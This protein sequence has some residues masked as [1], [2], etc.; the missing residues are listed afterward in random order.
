[1]YLFVCSQSFLRS[2]TAE[3]LCLLGGVEARCCGIDSSAL[4][5]VNNE[6][7]R[8]ADQVFCMEKRHR[9]GIKTY[10]GFDAAR[11]AVLNIPDDFE[12]FDPELVRLLVQK[13]GGL[14]EEVAEA[15]AHGYTMWH[16]GARRAKSYDPKMTVE[17]RIGLAR[18]LLKD[19]DPD[20]FSRDELDLVGAI[21]TG[22]HIVV[23]PPSLYLAREHD[24]EIVEN[25]YRRV[26]SPTRNANDFLELFSKFP[27]GTAIEEDPDEG[28]R[29]STHCYVD[30]SVSRG[31]Q[32]RETVLRSCAKRLKTLLANRDAFFARAAES[33]EKDEIKHTTLAM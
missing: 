33:Q 32:L 16:T 30:G 2:R 9:D 4:Y 24:F 18:E 26:F 25:G 13:I 27:I 22:K 17:A 19:R 6:L 5:P 23:L 8:S 29:Y 10:E 28:V 20:T 31:P 12:R 1:M 21:V 7:L 11:T 3:I 15:I 14:N